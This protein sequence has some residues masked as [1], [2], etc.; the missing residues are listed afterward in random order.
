[1][2]PGHGRPG[3]KIEIIPDRVRSTI[4]VMEIE[5]DS[6]VRKLFSQKKEVDFFRSAS[7]EEIFTHI[8]LT[9][10]WGDDETRSGKGSRLDSTTKLRA[11]LPDMLQ[12][13]EIKTMLDIP[14]GDFHWMKDVELPL[15]HYQGADIVEPLIDENRRRYGNEKREFLHMD[16]LNDPLPTVD[17]I[18]CRECLVHFS[19]ADIE[20]A[21]QNIKKS[22]S[23][24]LF[25]THFPER[26]FNEDVVTGKH[27]SLNFN[28]PPFNW[29]T[30][31]T[32]LTEYYAGKRRGNKC[33]SVWRI[34]DL[35]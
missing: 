33:L 19:Y 4:R 29:P 26:R 3:W 27:H 13:L 23:T 32:E 8:Y 22:G 30:P 11:A 9:N 7:T 12:Q 10:K 16:L 6:L 24:Y 31:I 15:A 5:R 20:K 35:P 14:C 34:A 2:V 28:L 1:M 17:A 21:L 18:F 25:A